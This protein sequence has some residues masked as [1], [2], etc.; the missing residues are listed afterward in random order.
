[1]IR[2]FARNPSDFSLRLAD[3]YRRL[4]PLMRTYCGMDR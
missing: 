2:F 3:I 1:M 4:Q